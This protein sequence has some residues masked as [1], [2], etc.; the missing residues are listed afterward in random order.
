MPCPSRLFCP[1]GTRT[2]I[3]GGDDKDTEACC[4]SGPRCIW[5]SWGETART[6]TADSVLALSCAPQSTHHV[7]C[8]KPGLNSAAR[9]LVDAVR[10]CSRLRIQL[11]LDL[12]WQFPVWVWEDPLWWLSGCFISSTQLSIMLTFKLSSVCFR[13]NTPL[14]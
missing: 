8:S 10:R 1:P 5:Q 6:G 12:K 2:H 9:S 13:V 7:P 14:K 3:I 11:Y 4:S